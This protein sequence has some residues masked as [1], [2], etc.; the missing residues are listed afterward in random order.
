[1]HPL[2]FALL[3]APLVVIDP[4]H[5]GAQQGAQGVCGLAEKD[6]TLK[7]AQTLEQLLL[8]TGHA[9]VLLTRRDNTDLSLERRAQLANDERAQLFL[10]I[11]ANAAEDTSSEGV[12]TFFLAARAQNGRILKIVDRENQGG[13]RTSSVGDIL[14]SLRLSF[15]HQES[16]RFAMALQSTLAR[17]LRTRSRGVR[18]APFAVLA[19][20]R[21]P[22]ALVEVGFLTHPEECERLRSTAYQLK[23][24]KLIARAVLVTLAGQEAER[25]A[26]RVER[27]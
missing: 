21:V 2:V 22:A 4:G 26:V 3:S 23:V 15:A 9:R 16:Q 11:H 17:E 13:V 18:Q 24:T 12:E 14:S 7:L 25:V 1:M 5:G 19:A 8:G 6:L 20:A 27:H 10:S